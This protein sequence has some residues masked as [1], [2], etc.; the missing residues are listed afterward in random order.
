M[1]I[2]TLK[3]IIENNTEKNRHNAG[4]MLYKNNL[5]SH[6]YIK[7]ENSNI[8]FYATVANEYYNELNTTLVVVNDK[9]HRLV[10]TSCDC[11]DWLTKSSENNTFICKHMVATV[12][13]CID[14]LKRKKLQ[15]NT[16]TSKF[17]NNEINY[18]NV[19]IS[20]SISNDKNN[21]LNFSFKIGDFNKSRCIDIY[22]AYKEN[23]R[24]YKIKESTYL[25]LHN[26]DIKDLLELIDIIKTSDEIDNIKIESNKAIYIDNYIKENN[27]NFIT[28]KEY[29]ERIT[30]KFD[31]DKKY[32]FNIPNE[33]KD[34]LRYYQKEGVNWFN[35]ISYYKFGGILADEMGLG[36][37][38]QTIAF[39]MNNKNSKSII[40]TPTSL[41]YN[42][43][44]EFDKFAPNIKLGI[45]HGDKKKREE[46]IDK[47][48]K[49]DVILT[50]Y[51]TIRNDLEKYK[52]KIFDYCIIDEA[53]NIKNPDAIITKTI[54]CIN[55]KVR[56]ALTGTPIENNLLELWSI[57]DFIMP[58][59]L[60]DKTEFKNRF[61]N[62][63]NT[64]KLKNLIKPF[65][66]RR[67]KKEV[68]KELPDKIEKKFIVELNKEQ[69][70]IYDIYNK[71]VLEKIKN[72]KDENDKITIFSYLTKLRQLCLHPRILLKDYSGKSSKIDICIDILKDAIENNRKILLFS[73]FTSILKLIAHEIEKNNIKYMY[74]DGK[75]KSE[76]R[77]K[78]VNE[79]NKNN[80]IKV[81]LISLKAGGT[82]LNL[83]SADM[84]IHFD[85]WWNIAVENQASDRAHRLGQENVVEVI[86]LISKDTIEE[87]IINLQESKKELIE[88]IIDDKLSNSKTLN[89]LSKEELIDLF[90]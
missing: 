33:L 30:S 24:L 81:F 46:I 90:K 60:Y 72:N 41:I 70:K 13:K 89:K 50:T 53:Q 16:Q 4:V 44:S 49:Y 23:K 84:V 39:I 85:P 62:S 3:T 74:L 19:K 2:S 63:D 38:L 73:Q 88:D 52:D 79:F 35:N 80:E 66:L 11:N 27:I 34:I 9:T 57:F 51:S 43:K 20:A 10:N 29:I 1:K 37:T 65:I 40:I 22:N 14:D 83:T 7:K 75:T 42:W 54:K 82:G 58:G 26:K 47:S 32:E 56:F 71:S 31:N 68:I 59:Y 8:N 18:V 87:K 61:I 78:L 48:N 5:V 17:S 28:G 12:F 76:D 55:S 77:I 15:K 36:K 25:D 45:V 67:T 69:K 86:K 64:N 6:S 21:N